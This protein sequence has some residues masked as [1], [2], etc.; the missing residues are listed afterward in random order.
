[1]EKKTISEMLAGEKI[2]LRKNNLSWAKHMFNCV[3]K[4]RNRLR[5]FLPWVDLTKSVTDTSNYIK[6]TEKEWEDCTE[7]DFGLFRA[8]D[9][10]YIGNFGVHTIAWQHNRCE[11]GYWIAGEFEGQGFVTDAVKTIERA[12]FKAGFNRIEVR[13]SSQN[14]RSS[15]V[16]ER[17]GYTLEGVLRKNYFINGVYHDTKVY[18]KLRTD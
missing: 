15:K 14:E 17:C 2:V 11:L 13:C 5:E 3:D 4:N 1:M 16:P 18:S 9:D 12:L 10:A 6:Q 7:F 8:S